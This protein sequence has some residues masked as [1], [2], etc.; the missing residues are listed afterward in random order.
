MRRDR[1]RRRTSDI[2]DPDVRE[3]DRRSPVVAR[4]EAR[5]AALGCV[6]S[7]YRR[8][9]VDYAAIG[10]AAEIYGVIPVAAA[11]SGIETVMV[12][13][14]AKRTRSAGPSFGRRNH[15][16]FLLRNTP[17]VLGNCIVERIFSAEAAGG[18]ASGPRSRERPKIA[19]GR[20]EPGFKEQRFAALDP[21]W[22]EVPWG[23][24]P[25]NAVLNDLA[26]R[27]RGTA[28]RSVDR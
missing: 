15:P 27:V 9:F 16:R 25:L 13:P 2:A 23:R 8:G 20:D 22:S 26:E 7:T 28:R 18:A 21:E 17:G 14:P 24:C 19:C 4:P 11:G 3:F 10:S 5:V 12:R 6:R 1:M